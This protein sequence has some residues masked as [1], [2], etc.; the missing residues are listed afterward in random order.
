[1]YIRGFVQVM[2]ILYYICMYIDKRCSADLIIYAEKCERGGDD[3][4]SFGIYNNNI[5][6]VYL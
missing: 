4:S 3:V 5:C 6:Y 1:M 2:Y